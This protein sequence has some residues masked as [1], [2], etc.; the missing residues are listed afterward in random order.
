M[1]LFNLGSSAPQY[2]EQASFDEAVYRFY[3]LRHQY[4]DF[5][6]FWHAKTN[7]SNGEVRLVDSLLVNASKY[8]K[9][10]TLRSQLSEACLEIEK[11]WNKKFGSSPE[12]LSIFG[13]IYSQS[14][15]AM[16][17]LQTQAV[18]I[19]QA[20]AH[21]NLATRVEACMRNLYRYEMQIQHKKP[22]RFDDQ[23]K[24]HFYLDGLNE[25]LSSSYK[26]S[27][28]V[29]KVLEQDSY[30]QSED[31]TWGR[32][33]LFRDSTG[34]SDVWI[35]KIQNGKADVFSAVEK[36]NQDTFELDES[37]R[38]IH[39]DSEIFKAIDKTQVTAFDNSEFN[40][41]PPAYFQMLAMLNATGEKVF[42]G[43]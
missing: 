20:E 18:D 2:M 17:K 5:Q 25:T 39:F 4:E 3:R 7:G 26:Y 31:V 12:S 21:V 13:V 24:I 32:W 19:K 10:E 28:S 38:G 15:E 35:V 33:T 30:I 34:F 42:D 11:Y 43:R 36:L 41:S 40:L 1:A 8:P 22:I 6:S 23:I 14:E 27:G 37:I 9:D 16:L 29:L